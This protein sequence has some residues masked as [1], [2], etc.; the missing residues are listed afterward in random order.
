MHSLNTTMSDVELLL[1]DHDHA[2]TRTKKEKQVPLIKAA[3]A[4]F[5]GTFI[6]IVFGNGVC[7]QSVL[8]GGK[9]AGFLSINFGWAIGVIMGIYCTGSSSGGHLNP[10]IHNNIYR[11]VVV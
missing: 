11:S 10:G 2:P 1:N 4:E 3:M 7:A 8:S 9:L 5:L 6:M